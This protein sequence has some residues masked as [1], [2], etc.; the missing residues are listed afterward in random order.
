MACH[1]TRSVMSRTLSTT[2]TGN[3]YST[4]SSSNPTDTSEPEDK[5][6]FP[7]GLV[8]DASWAKNVTALGDSYTAAIG[9][10]QELDAKA[11]R[12][13]GSY[14][15]LVRELLSNPTKNPDFQFIAYSGAVSKE[16]LDQVAS[17]DDQSQDLVL[18]TAGGNDALL[19]ALLKACIYTP[20]NAKNCDNAINNSQKVITK[21]LRRNIRN[22]LL[23]LSTK[24]AKNG[25]VVYTLYAQFFNSE[26]QACNKRS[27]SLLEG[28]VLKNT[29]VFWTQ[30]LRRKLNKLVVDANREIQ[31]AII[32]VKD[33]INVEI[34]D[35]DPI[36]K[37]NNGRFCEPG[38]VDK[39][40]DEKNAGLLFNRLDVGV[41]D[42]V[43]KR[44][45]DLSSGSIER[46]N[47]IEK[48]HIT[49]TFHPN[50][51]GQIVIA[52]EVMA[53]IDRHRQTLAN[54]KREPICS[55]PEITEAK[56]L[57]R[58]KFIAQRESDGPVNMEKT[59]QDWCEKNK[60][61]NVGKVAGGT[62]TDGR[63]SLSSGQENKADRCNS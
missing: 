60:G 26:T 11:R 40:R 45:G 28:I 31:D 52:G 53:A 6:N 47:Y 13:S 22:L 23:D 36:A 4:T 61:V 33:K 10:G 5:L 20:T 57:R 51:L 59:I 38:V 42:L 30:D 19:T 56:C 37:A 32:D 50:P 35:W 14:A 63:L 27:M 29:A 54:K 44:R 62:S 25:L 16:I 43:H 58:K 24:M 15:L 49:F 48:S 18:M 21:D 12:Y 3:K 46:R 41:P 9:V 8:E 7:A 34:A 2:T 1:P 17:L 55:K 39:Y